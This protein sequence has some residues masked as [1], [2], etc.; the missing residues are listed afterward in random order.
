MNNKQ[1]NKY[2][3]SYKYNVMRHGVFYIPLNDVS[4]NWSSGED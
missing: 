4:T 1:I 2:V 3:T